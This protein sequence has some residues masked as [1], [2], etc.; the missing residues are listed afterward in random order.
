MPFDLI[1]DTD[2][3]SVFIH[4]IFGAV[5]CLMFIASFF[6]LLKLPLFEKNVWNF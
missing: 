2:I 1:L 6:F 3:Q 4:M 5:E